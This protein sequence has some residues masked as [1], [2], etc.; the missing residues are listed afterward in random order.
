MTATL[1]RW[2]RLSFRLQRW[3]VLA[4]VAGVVA[5]TAVMLWLSVELRRIAASEPGCLD[6]HA[7]VPGCEALAQRFQG[8]ADLG[9]GLLYLAWGAP[10]G[11]GLLL[12]VPIVSREVES[13]TASLAWTLDRSR[14]RWLVARLAFAAMVL[15]ALLVIVMVASGTL[16]AAI[17]PQLHLDRDFTWYGHRDWLIVGR[18]L[19]A[20]GIGVLVGA[21]VGRVLPG[22]LTAAFASVLVFAG[23]SLAMDRWNDSLGVVLDTSTPDGARAAEGALWVG[24]AIKLPDGRIARW[25][26]VPAARDAQCGDVDG[27]LY[28]RCDEETGEPDPTSLVGW[29]RGIIVA[30]SRY[31]EVLARESGIVAGVGLLMA[32]AAVS[33]ARR[34]RP[35]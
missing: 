35:A 25:E 4:S 29:D 13:G 6:P 21:A 18:G 24:S 26:D 27:S 8:P 2:A 1:A 33:V 5:L 32:G 16:A 10:F 28:T 3:E 20:L 19:A 12:G 14:G 31:P 23:V 9:T 7:Y 34:R 15:V 11:M 17:R 22:L 30:G